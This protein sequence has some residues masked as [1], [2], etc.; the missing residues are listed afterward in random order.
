MYKKI[1]AAIAD[2]EISWNALQE[3]I[4]IATANGAKLCIVHAMP[5]AS[6][7][8]KNRSSKRAG[9]EVLERAKAE[10]AATPAI[11]VETRLVAAEGEYGLKGI[12]DAIAAA[13]ADWGADLLVVGTKGR[14]GLERLVIG[15]VAEQLV[16]T[17]VASILLARTH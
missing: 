9:E 15:S 17:V 7:D 2:D 3:A 12:S 4:H 13:V 8:E 10:L 5:T 16:S 6:D 14:R 11:A 1:M